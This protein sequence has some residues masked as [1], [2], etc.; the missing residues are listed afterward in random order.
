[1]A[2]HIVTA[3]TQGMKAGFNQRKRTIKR[4]G[5]DIPVGTFGDYCAKFGPDVD[6]YKASMRQ[7]RKPQALAGVQVFADDVAEDVFADELATLR[8]RI[9]EIEAEKQ[10]ASKPKAQRKQRTKAAKENLWRPWA[11]RKHSIPT[12]VGATFVYKGKRRT[13]TFR[14]TRVTSEGVY[15]TRVS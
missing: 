10:A 3:A 15:S 7:P 1:M 9:A 5:L 11:V 13:T 4:G 6:A 14:V 12:T 2:T 8:Q